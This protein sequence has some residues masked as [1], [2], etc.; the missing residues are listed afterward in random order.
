MERWGACTNVFPLVSGYG[1]TQHIGTAYWRESHL[2]GL[3]ER[4]NRA[5]YTE[6]EH[7]YVQTNPRRRESPF[8]SLE[9]QRGSHIGAWVDFFEYLQGLDA[10]GISLEAE[11]YYLCS[12]GY[13]LWDTSR[14]V[15]LEVTKSQAA[16]LHRTEAEAAWEM[17]ITMRGFW[18]HRY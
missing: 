1:L 4:E 12:W 18:S 15:A 9:D 5:L 16:R 8:V 10:D 17:R 13:A 7:I 11:H 3:D 2:P 14:I 6:Y